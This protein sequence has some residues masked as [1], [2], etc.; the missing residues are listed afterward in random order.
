MCEEDDDL[1]MFLQAMK[2]EN[3]LQL[4]DTMKEELSS[5]DNNYIWS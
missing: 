3:F 4:L 1:E 5:I 2:V